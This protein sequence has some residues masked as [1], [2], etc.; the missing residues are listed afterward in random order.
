MQIES[1]RR[2]AARVLFQTCLSHFSD[3]KVDV[4]LM[5]ETLL[6]WWWDKRVSPISFLF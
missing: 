2:D 5:H 4:W 3:M 6:G 1:R